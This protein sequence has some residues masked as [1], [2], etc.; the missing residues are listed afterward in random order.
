MALKAGRRRSVCGRSFLGIVVLALVHA[1]EAFA[2]EPASVPTFFART[3]YAPDLQGG[4]AATPLSTPLLI[5]DTFAL[6]SVAEPN[7]F[8]EKDFRPRGRSILDSD[9]RLNVADD[10]LIANTTVWQRLSRFRGVR[11][12]VQVLTLWRSGV[13][14][15]A[16]QAGKRGDPTLQWTSSLLNRGRS[17]QGLLDELF[18]VTAL[19]E[20]PA[21][22]TISLHP[23]A[24]SST[25]PSAPKGVSSISGWRLG[26]SAAP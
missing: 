5:P 20:S 15:L 22:H 16:L 18:P 26:T 23:A 12:R 11:D 25:S 7:S 1:G 8:S 13:G 17:A 3:P 2:G 4:R 6:P 10:A 14:T 24:A 9:F 19:S 21:T